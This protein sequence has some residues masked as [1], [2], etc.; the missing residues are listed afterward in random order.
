MAEA[1]NCE[2]NIDGSART[3]EISL[4]I[5][6]NN[7]KSLSNFPHRCQAGVKEIGNHLLHTD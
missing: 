6:Q 2:M 7:K 3:A 1:K 4:R 5:T